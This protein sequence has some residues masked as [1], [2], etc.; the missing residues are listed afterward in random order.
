VCSHCGAALSPDSRECPSCS[1][2]CIFNDESGAWEFSEPPDFKA[3]RETFKSRGPPRGGKPVSRGT[4]PEN[5]VK[6][7]VLNYLKLRHIYCWSNPSGAVKIRPGKFMSFGL[8]GGSDI[9]G[10]LPGGRFLAAECKALAG[11]IRCGSK[12]HSLTGAPGMWTPKRAPD[13]S[14][15]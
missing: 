8:K 11:R 2:I 1:R 7:E 3:I 15:R 4:T 9:L 10:I 14:P 13:W 12:Q 5:R 6:S